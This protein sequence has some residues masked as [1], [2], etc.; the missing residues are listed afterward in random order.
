MSKKPITKILQWKSEYLGYLLLEFLLSRFSL[1]T[2]YRLG[3]FLGLILCKV[4]PYYRGIVKRNLMMTLGKD[5]IVDPP[6]SA[7]EEVFMRNSGNMLTTLA[8][9]RKKITDISQYLEIRGE[10]EVEASLENTGVI[11][12]MGH[13]GNWEILTKMTHGFDTTNTLGALYRPLNNPYMNELI[14]KRRK[15]SGMELISRRNPIKSILSH[16]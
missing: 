15:A 8:T 1:Y 9:G 2:V 12:I 6:D 3:E 13:M 10:N 16:F 11:L 4:S 5:D 14:L 7:V